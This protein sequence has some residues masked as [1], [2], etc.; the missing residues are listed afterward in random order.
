MR[1]SED[2]PKLFRSIFACIREL[3]R[4]RIFAW[5][6]NTAQRHRRHNKD[7][8]KL[9]RTIFALYVSLGQ[10][11]AWLANTTT[12]NRRHYKDCPKV[13]RSIFALYVRLGQSFF[14]WF[15]NR[16]RLIGLVLS[17][18]SDILSTY[19]IMSWCTVVL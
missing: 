4:S 16:N 14:A 15:A 10:S 7:C 12:Y 5:F 2:C 9:L 6:A 3:F 18:I 13:F 8:P 1:K 11:F 19:L 17:S